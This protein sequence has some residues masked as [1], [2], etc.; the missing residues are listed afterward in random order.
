[1]LIHEF[2][3]FFWSALLAL[4]HSMLIN[5]FED[6]CAHSGFSGR[7][8]IKAVKA[9]PAARSV[10]ARFKGYSRLPMCKTR[11]TCKESMWT[12]EMRRSYPPL[13]SAQ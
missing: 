4:E 5:E 12:A 8:F 10:C 1:M 11:Q 3:E 9:S 13:P 6:V 2:E 7:D